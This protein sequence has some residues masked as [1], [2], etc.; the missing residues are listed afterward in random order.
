V[1]FE[2]SFYCVSKKIDLM[3]VIY[4]GND[5]NDA[6]VMGVVGYPVCPSDA[7]ASIKDIENSI[8]S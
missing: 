5:I 1:S 2:F 4:V 6:S 3:N 8:N 7:Y